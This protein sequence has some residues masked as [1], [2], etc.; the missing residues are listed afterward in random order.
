MS[1]KF[2][3]LVLAFVFICCNKLQADTI[4]L[5]NGRSISG[6]IK[7]QEQ[8]FVELEVSG[9]SVKFKRSEIDRIEK[10]GTEERTLIRQRWET[11]KQQNLER[12]IRQQ[13][14][15]ESKPKEAIF[16]R[17]SLGITLA[18]KINNKIEAKLV[19]DTGATLV[20]L[21]RD[22]A[23]SLGI[24]LDD[25][26]PDIKLMLAD[27]RKIN[28]KF[29][30]LESVKVQDS[31]AKNVEAAIMLEEAGDFGFGDGLLGMSFLK[32][33]NFKVDYKEKKLILEKL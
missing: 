2:N 31:E 27:G 22:L 29:I 32:R 20:V 14:E 9:G 21:R 4:Y 13:H 26:K 16:S 15:E 5:M 30:T 18:V 25:A 1:I 17:D 8:D 11:Q 12:L 19:L 28:A 10:S 7:S 33:F 24:N 3:L 23:A 6:I